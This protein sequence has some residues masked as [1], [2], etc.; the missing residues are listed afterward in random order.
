M[1]KTVLIILADGFEEL[2]AVGTI[3]ILRRAGCS[4]IVAALRDKTVTS[5]R[6]IKIQADVLLSEVSEPVDALILPGGDA[7]AKNLSESATVKT[8]IRRLNDEKKWI[9]AICAA[10]AV[11][12]APTG[13]LD[14]RKA[15]G[16]PGTETGF[17]SSTKILSEAVVVDGHII[18]A[19]GPGFTIPF[20]L[21][22]AEKL[23]G[24]ETSKKIKQD[25]LIL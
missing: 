19:S 17:S 22:L 5:A 15:T 23:C 8:W 13:I 25:L 7:G 20:A 3:D 4:V 21:T 12:L 11:V 6:K 14:G 2:E 16:Y 9:A 18:T 1:T 10:P 24:T